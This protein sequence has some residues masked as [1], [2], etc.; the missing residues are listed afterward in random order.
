LFPRSD[1]AVAP[2]SEVGFPLKRLPR[3]KAE[4][5]DDDFSFIIGRALRGTFPVLDRGR[6]NEVTTDGAIV[7]DA[8][9]ARVGIADKID[10]SF[11][12]LSI[13]QVQKL[14]SASK[15]KTLWFFRDSALDSA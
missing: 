15:R 4:P 2:S 13:A 3:E 1:V 5:S 14:Q 8:I 9:R 11:I 7:K 10:G 6:E 12:F